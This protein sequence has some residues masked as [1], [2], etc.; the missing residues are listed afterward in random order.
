MTSL[1]Q[2]KIRAK[3]LG[4]DLWETGGYYRLSGLIHGTHTQG[5]FTNLRSVERQLAKLNKQKKT[6]TIGSL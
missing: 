2:L 6:F 3:N 1:K 5:E 4:L